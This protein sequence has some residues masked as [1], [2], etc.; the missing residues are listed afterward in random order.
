MLEKE[1]F[2]GTCSRGDEP[3]GTV[4]G[5]ELTWQSDLA[6]KV[7]QT[8]LKLSRMWS[9]P[10]VLN[11]KM[12][13]QQLLHFWALPLYTGCNFHLSLSNLVCIKNL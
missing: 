11:K 9:Y 8:P 13:I 5:A 2:L 7:L 1:A 3:Q 12:Q 4:Q 6:T 10:Q